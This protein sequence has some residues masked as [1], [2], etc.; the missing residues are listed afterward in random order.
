M[1]VASRG[2]TDQEAEE[3][4]RDVG[5]ALTAGEGREE[6]IAKSQTLSGEGIKKEGDRGSD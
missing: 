2:S 4:G 5:W 3:D 1:R 6:V